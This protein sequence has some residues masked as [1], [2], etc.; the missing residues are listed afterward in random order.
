MFC[1]KKKTVP[2]WQERLEPVRLE[3]VDVAGAVPDSASRLNPA[4]KLL[5]FRG[6]WNRGE[7]PLAATSPPL[8][9]NC[10]ETFSTKAKYV[11]LCTRK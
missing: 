1:E 11:F 6:L 10:P 7:P 9:A 4:A 2:A 3:S 5:R 8:T